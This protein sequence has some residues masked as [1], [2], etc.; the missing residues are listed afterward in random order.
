MITPC[1]AYGAPDHGALKELVEFQAGTGVAGLFVLGTAG[2]GPMFSPE[3]RGGLLRTIVAAAAG[4]LAVVAHIGAM[5]TS[6]AVSIAADAVEA[7]ADA[8][9]SVP[10]V[11]YN[12][13]RREVDAYYRSIKEAVGDVDVLAYNNPAATSY[14]MSPQQAIELSNEGTITAVKQASTSVEDLHQMLRGG[15]S[16]WMANATYNTAALAMGAVGA[17]STITNVAPEKF[18]GLYNAVQAR[19]LVT[20]RNVQ[21]QIDTIQANLRS[22]IIGALHHAVTLR[23]L[24]G[25]SPRAPL[26]LP[27][28][29][30]FPAIELSVK[31]ATS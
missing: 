3:E 20:A 4:K 27:D 13:G 1:D 24:P 23:G 6:T 11:Y 30:Q 7:G 9:S 17:V 31:I 5:P 15:V 10:P 8:I 12:P 22:P 21:H 19:D 16:V 14:R 18:V 25:L 29:A 2:Q 28:S 26:M